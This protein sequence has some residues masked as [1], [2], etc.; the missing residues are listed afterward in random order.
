MTT[1]RHI[2]NDWLRTQIWQPVVEQPDL[3]FQVHCIDCVALTC[4]HAA[5]LLLALG[6]RH[7]AAAR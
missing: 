3:C 4:P 5:V 6:E 7:L 1:E 2:P